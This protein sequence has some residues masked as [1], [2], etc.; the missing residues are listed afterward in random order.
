MHRKWVEV[1]ATA[2]LAGHSD[3]E[4]DHVCQQQYVKLHSERIPMQES[5]YFKQFVGGKEVK[6]IQPKCA[7][8]D[9]CAALCQ[10]GACSHSVF[11]TSSFLYSCD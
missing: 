9:Y 5:L 7:C 6:P 10:C 11:H 2:N 4:R 8:C 3:M 1:A